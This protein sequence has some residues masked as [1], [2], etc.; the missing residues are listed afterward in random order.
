M[1]ENQFKHIRARVSVVS[2]NEVKESVIGERVEDYTNHFN[3]LYLEKIKARI[4]HSNWGVIFKQ[5]DESIPKF[6]VDIYTD[7]NVDHSIIKACIQN[8]P[9]DN[10]ELFINE[11]YWN[12]SKYME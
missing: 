4:S 11:P 3:D 10:I 6:E 1:S 5:S 12:F 2:E 7:N 8:N 9:P